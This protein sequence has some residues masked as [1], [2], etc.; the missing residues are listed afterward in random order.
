MILISGSK[1]VKFAQK[2]RIFL[3][4]FTLEGTL[5]TSVALYPLSYREVVAILHKMT[6]KN[7]RRRL[8]QNI[9]VLK[10]ILSLT[11]NGKILP[12]TAK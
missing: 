10:A 1:S 5:I 2:F 6:V 12:L 8:R 11:A 9:I 7:P 3:K 4:F